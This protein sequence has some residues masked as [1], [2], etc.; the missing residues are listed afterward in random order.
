MH[1][2]FNAKYYSTSS[3]DTLSDEKLVSSL[4][5]INKI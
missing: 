2:I 5:D 3:I 1:K 4:A